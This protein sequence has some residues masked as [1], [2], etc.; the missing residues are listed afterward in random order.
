[1][2]QKRPPRVRPYALPALRGPRPLGADKRRMI[3]IRLD[4]KLLAALRAEAA[5]RRIPYQTLIHETLC[6]HPPV[7]RRMLV[8]AEAHTR[9]HTR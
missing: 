1:M 4:P 9:R 8:A 7:F 2:T 3:S 6:I 5:H